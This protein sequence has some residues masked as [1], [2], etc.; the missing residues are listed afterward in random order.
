MDVP[1]LVGLGVHPL[2]PFLAE[3]Q[4][5]AQKGAKP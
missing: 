1:A 3:V 5:R 4:V 2:V